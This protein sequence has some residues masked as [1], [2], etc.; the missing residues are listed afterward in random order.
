MREGRSSKTAAY[1]ALLRA[2][3]DRGLTSA[4][5]FSDPAA[6]RLLPPRWARA[7]TWLEARV[8][9]LPAWARERIA[10]RVD[11]LVVR[12][13]AVDA[14]V[15]AALA[16]GVEQV[17]VLGAGFDG[18]AHRMAE[19]RRAHVFE[20][21]HPATQSIKL[22]RVGGLPRTSRHLSYVACDFERE[23]LSDRLKCAGH[24]SSVPTL[25]I[26][27]GVTLYLEDAAIR[28]TLTAIR[29]RSAPGSTLVVEYH[30]AEAPSFDPYYAL[31][32][33]IVLAVWS[34]PHI[35]RRSRQKM[36]AE[37][38]DADFRLSKDFAISE[39]GTAFANA[40]PSAARRARLAVATFGS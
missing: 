36:R 13:L 38:E 39:W 9:T 33:K 28:A 2:L 16:L 25:W 19:L 14:E 29:A 1:V 5:G 11:L 21:D 3:G 37:L 7:F 18:R 20:V 40:A 4:K 26:W 12:S 30:D 8:H 31:V 10:A 23:A 24:R 32:R 35:G 34:E 22:H 15:T 6:R 27:E 17:V